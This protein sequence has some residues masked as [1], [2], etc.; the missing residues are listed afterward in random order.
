MNDNDRA[1]LLARADNHENIASTHPE[2]SRW[3]VAFA[4][5]AR[6]LRELCDPGLVAA[7]GAREAPG[8]SNSSPRLPST[9]VRA[10]AAVS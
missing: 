8:G 7:A 1:N 4:D 2:G 10:T 3:A 5:A 9:P 6:Q